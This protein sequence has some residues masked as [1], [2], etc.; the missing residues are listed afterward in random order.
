[1]PPLILKI[2]IKCH[3]DVLTHA[4]NY[5]GQLHSNKENEG[6]SACKLYNFTDVNTIKLIY[7]QFQL[8]PDL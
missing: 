1:M 8:N 5:W 6:Q 2:I 7:V 4:V 3:F